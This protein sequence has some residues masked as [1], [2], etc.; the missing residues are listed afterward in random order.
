MLVEMDTSNHIQEIYTKILLRHDSTSFPTIFVLNG[1]QLYCIE[2][3]VAFQEFKSAFQKIVQCV[4]APSYTS[5][6]C[7]LIAK[8]SIIAVHGFAENQTDYDLF[9][10]QYLISIENAFHL[11]YA[12]RP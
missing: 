9:R 11:M 6:F 12:F 8:E 2:H 1:T 5:L 7:R 10:L 4:Q 3:A